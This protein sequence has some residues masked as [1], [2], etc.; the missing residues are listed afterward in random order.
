ME[1]FSTVFQPPT[2]SPVKLVPDNF[3]EARGHIFEAPVPTGICCDHAILIRICPIL[4][5]QNFQKRLT[6]QRSH[7]II[8]LISV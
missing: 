2:Q 1:N 4:I 8:S 6:L 3:T 7:V 5:Y